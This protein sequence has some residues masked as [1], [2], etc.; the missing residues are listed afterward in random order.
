M[1]SYAVLLVSLVFASCASLTLENV[2]YGWPVESV[3]TV[4][5]ANTFEDVR[6][7][8]SGRVARL[9]LDQFQDSTALRGAKL[10]LIRSSEG[11]YFLTGPKF[12][13]V[14][15]FSPAQGELSL[16]SRIEVAPNGLQSP[17]LNQR[18][19]YIEVTDVGGFSRLLTQS[20]IVQVTK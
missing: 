2:D 1:K 5:N 19:P 14:Y 12:K 13:N 10:R 15:V 18:R 11:M 7:A 6:Y 8:L 9:A 17:A 3:V 4:S 20:D 16:Q